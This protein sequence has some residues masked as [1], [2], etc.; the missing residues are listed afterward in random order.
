MSEQERFLQDQIDKLPRGWDHLRT[1]RY[2]FLFNAEKSFV[3]DMGD[4]I[5]SIRN[6]YEELYPPEGEGISAACLYVSAQALLA[7]PK[8][9]AQETQ[10]RHTK[11][12][13]GIA[14]Y[15]TRSSKSSV[16]RR[17]RQSG[18]PDWEFLRGHP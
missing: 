2:L 7:G 16:P 6:T 4:Q 8:R 11:S 15:V 13:K 1:D 14:S 9:Q 3:K 18:F 17:S 5:E 10:Q 12:E